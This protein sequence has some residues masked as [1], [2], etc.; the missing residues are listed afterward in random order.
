MIG[1]ERGKK[2]RENN[3]AKNK[4]IF[5]ELPPMLLVLKV[6]VAVGLLRTFPAPR[7]V[8]DLFVT[9]RDLRMNHSRVRGE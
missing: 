5:D 2:G 4:Q 7:A 8:P 1:K 9:D 6:V 3:C